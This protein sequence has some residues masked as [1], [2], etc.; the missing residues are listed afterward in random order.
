MRKE[1]TIT[2]DVLSYYNVE[3]LVGIH[4]TNHWKH[5]HLLGGVIRMSVDNISPGDVCLIITN[6]TMV[7]YLLPY[8]VECFAKVET[9]I[10]AVE[11]IKEFSDIPQEASWTSHE[12]EKPQRIGPH[13]VS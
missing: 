3:S 13:L 1:L 8:L 6:A 11:S 7:S 2:K 5:Y 4:Y 9:S 10:V 12:Y